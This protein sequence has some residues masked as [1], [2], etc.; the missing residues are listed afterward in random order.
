MK[1]EDDCNTLVFEERA[2]Q[3]WVRE[4]KNVILNMTDSKRKQEAWNKL[5]PPFVSDDSYLEGT[6]F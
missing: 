4:R 5:F 6:I 3:A 1:D 2:Y